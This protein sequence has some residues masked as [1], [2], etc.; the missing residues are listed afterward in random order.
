M[1]K[2]C[3]LRK[4]PYKGIPLQ[5]Q[6]SQSPPYSTDLKRKT[7]NKSGLQMMP[8]QG[9]IS[10]I[11]NHGGIASQNK[12][13]IMDT[14]LMP[15]KPSSWSR[16]VDLKAC[17]IFKG[18]GITI[19]TDGTKYQGAAIGTQSLENYVQQKINGWVTEEE[20]L[21]FIAIS[22]PQA[23]YVALTHGVITKW[24]YLARTIPNIADL[25]KPLEDVIHQRFL[26]A[27]TGQ[28]AFNDDNRD[29]MALPSCLGGLG[30]VIPTH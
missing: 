20:H 16:K 7:L 15:L 21:S 22:Q 25:F 8:L 10:V 9:E 2:P 4:T 13:L 30:I 12:D 28:N 19:N 18:T 6:C 26:P 17:T 11:S 23:A 27:I 14:T 5:W 29:L 3:S 24:T 1:G